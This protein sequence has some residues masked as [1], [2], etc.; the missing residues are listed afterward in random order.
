MSHA[1]CIFDLENMVDNAGIGKE[2]ILLKQPALFVMLDYF[3]LSSYQLQACAL[4]TGSSRLGLTAWS[5][6]PSSTLKP[7]ALKAENRKLPEITGPELRCI[8]GLK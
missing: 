4:L 3:Q 2:V 7:W 1:A 8:P 6:A 5:A